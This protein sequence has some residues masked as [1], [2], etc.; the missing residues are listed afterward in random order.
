MR[1]VIT[2]MLGLAAIAA[3]GAAQES[4]ISD[5]VASAIPSSSF[6]TPDCGI[7]EG[8]FLVGSGSTYLKSASETSVPANKTRMYSDA[9]RVLTD[10]ITQKG[11]AD[12]AAAWYYL[13]RAY[14]R[15][16]D[17][18]G[19]DSAF[20]RAEALAPECVE[21]IN[22]FRRNAWVAL[23][24][25]GVEFLQAGEDDSAA[26]VLSQANIV[27]QGE[28]NALYYTGIMFAN[29]AE[30]DSAAWYFERA[31]DVAN[32]HEEFYEDRNK[33]TFNLAIVLGN[34]DRWDDAVAT[35]HQY[36]EW[37][38]DDLEAQKALAHAYRNNGQAEQAAELE[39]MLLAAVASE[40]LDTE[41]MSTSDV[42]NFGVNAF[43]D[44]NFG[45]A[46]A[47][48]GT[49]LVREPH[50]R[51]AMYNRSNALYAL[52]AT[53]GEQADAF[54]AAGSTDQAA[55]ADVALGEQAQQLIESSEALL[56]HDPLNEDAQKLQGEGYRVTENQEKL[57]EIFTAITAAP[58][59]VQVSGFER[60]A[61][62][63]VFTAVA[64]GRQPQ[65]IQGDNIEATPVT[66]IVEFLTD[67]G[68]V[69]SDTT[70]TIPVLAPAATEQIRAEAEGSGITW[71]RYRQ[72]S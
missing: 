37:V 22:G 47:A 35:W 26:V 33:S 42:Y 40:A 32:Q 25:P 69:V 55:A 28:P 14:M 11:Q 52:M 71:W 58:V 2:A 65:D 50:N 68:E 29:A 53:T 44:G 23:V 31:A 7:K 61:D 48:F 57:L 18:V 49:V 16:G 12:N 39:A 30:P 51:D 62:G 6:T 64:T 36:L 72:T 38:P 8:H 3:N 46:I 19:L 20:T 67:D 43:N 70:I 17:L 1:T 21:D 45:G 66:I 15:Q 34:L 41:G 54:R 10:A 13:G 60:G 5:R 4:V 63:A 56:A 59:T 27:Y 24:R 9:V